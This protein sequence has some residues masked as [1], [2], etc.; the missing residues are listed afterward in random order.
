[1]NNLSQRPEPSLVFLFAKLYIQQSVR[2]LEDL[3][4]RC[5]CKW[6][7]LRGPGVSPSTLFSFLHLNGPTF[8]RL[9]KPYV[10]YP[11]P[12]PSETSIASLLVISGRRTLPVMIVL[13]LIEA[14]QDTSTFECPVH[15]PLTKALLLSH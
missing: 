4:S 11:A 1:M 8:I 13:K 12:V 3:S 7:G 15:T 10:C 2:I 9:P 6:M 14:D 5:L